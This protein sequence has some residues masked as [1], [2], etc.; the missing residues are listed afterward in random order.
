MVID[1][2]ALGVLLFCINIIL[3]KSEKLRNNFGWFIQIFTFLVSYVTFSSEV[4]I[5]KKMGNVKSYQIF[6]LRCFNIII[7]FFYIQQF[8]INWV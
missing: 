4:D 6:Y 2:I 5:L 7:P 3:R 8:L 1:L